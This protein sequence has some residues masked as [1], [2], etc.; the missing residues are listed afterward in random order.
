MWY[1]GTIWPS[2]TSTVT[3]QS[4]KLSECNM[5]YLTKQNT[6]K[7]ILTWCTRAEHEKFFMYYSCS[8]HLFR[9]RKKSHYKFGPYPDLSW[10]RFHLKVPAKLT[11]S[12]HD[13][14]IPLILYI[15]PSLFFVM[16]T[17]KFAPWNTINFLWLISFKAWVKIASAAQNRTA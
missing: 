8:I 9:S 5:K 12:T 1:V 10:F 11:W 2:E 7:P 15:L 17:K 16:P 13:S 14:D 4:R 3:F 6:L